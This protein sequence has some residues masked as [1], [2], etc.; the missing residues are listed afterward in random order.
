M[1]RW[2]IIGAL[3]RKARSRALMYPLD[4]S[5]SEVTALGSV[6]W[7]CPGLWYVG[8]GTGQV[9]FFARFVALQI[10]ANLIGK[11]LPVYPDTTCRGS[12]S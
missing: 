4:V 5:S 3:T 7:N 9:R 1:R 12:L 8:G 2:R 10:L 6:D 11:P